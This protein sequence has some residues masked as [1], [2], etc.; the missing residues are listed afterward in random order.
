MSLRINLHQFGRYFMIENFS[1]RKQVEQ[2]NKARSAEW[3]RRMRE[4]AE[5]FRFSIV[6]MERDFICELIL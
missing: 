5:Q 2:L 3:E 6:Q 4:K 1:F